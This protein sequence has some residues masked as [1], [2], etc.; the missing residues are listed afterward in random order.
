MSR[1][2]CQQNQQPDFF[3]TGSHLSTPMEGTGF[4]GI[5]CDVCEQEIAE[6]ATLITNKGIPEDPLDICPSFLT[7]QLLLSRK[8]SLTSITKLKAARDGHAFGFLSDLVREFRDL[9]LQNL[10]YS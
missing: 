4:L 6:N 1:Q 7:V 3:K 2:G 8:N 9:P 5:R 10:A